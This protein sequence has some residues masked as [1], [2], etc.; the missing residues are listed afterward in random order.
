MKSKLFR[1]FRY[2]PVYTRWLIEL[3][4]CVAAYFILL[5]MFVSS[6]R[7][8]MIDHLYTSIFLGT[9]ILASTV[10][11]W[12]I[13]KRFL[14]PRTFWIFLFLFVANILLWTWFNQLLFDRLI[15]YLLPGYYFISYYEFGDLC[16]SVRLTAPTFWPGL[17]PANN[18]Q[19]ARESVKIRITRSSLSTFSRSSIRHQ[20]RSP[21]CV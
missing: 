19:P 18:S 2:N 5:K 8:S 1:S 14:N 4:F 12:V 17:T 13:R 7:V 3:A 9:L 16:R 10:N 21:C 6:S 20:R 11:S 15:D